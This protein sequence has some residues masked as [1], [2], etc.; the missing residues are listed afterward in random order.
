MGLIGLAHEG[1]RFLGV[2]SQLQDL[3]DAAAIA[4]ARELDGEAGALTRAETEARTLLDNNPRW[5]EGGRALQL[6]S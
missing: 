3:A 2:N 4:G 1:G 5:A 6:H